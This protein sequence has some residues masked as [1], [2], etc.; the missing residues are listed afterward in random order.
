MKTTSRLSA[1]E[2]HEN[3]KHTWQPTYAENI[4][5]R[6]SAYLFPVIGRK[7]ITEIKPV[8]LLHALRPIEEDGKH[9][10]AHRMLQTSGQIFRYA[11][12]CGK[13]ERDITQ[14]LRGALKPAKSKTYPHLKEDELPPFLKKLN[15]YELDKEQGG[16]NGSEIVKWGFQ[17]LI[18]TFVRTGEIRGMRWDE[19]D[20]NKKQWRIPEERMKMREQH[21]VPLSDQAITILKK[22][23]EVTGNSYSGYVFPSFQNLR[24]TISENTFLRA[25]FLMGY[26][27]KTVGH[28][29]RSTASTI[30]NENGFRPDIIERQLA[31]CERDQVRAAYNHAQ[32]RMIQ[33]IFRQ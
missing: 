13:T 9:E 31:H 28:G 29:F 8:E 16:C 5:K 24:K 20:W 23:Q 21:I 7:P 6:L 2:W 25:I 17:L 32:F 1:R 14:D 12:A 15:L 30:L 26:K 3:K 22:L 11:V 4:L 19:I 33:R 10:M 27:G 18:M